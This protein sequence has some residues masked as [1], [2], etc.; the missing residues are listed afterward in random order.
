MF[1]RRPY[2]N[3]WSISLMVFAI[4]NALYV[5]VFDGVKDQSFLLGDDATVALVTGGFGL[6]GLWLGQ[7]QKFASGGP[8]QGRSLMPNLLFCMGIA[9]VVT[10][11]IVGMAAYA[12]SHG[13]IDLKGVIIGTI[14]ASV[15][16]VCNMMLGL[17][18]GL[19]E[20]DEDT[21]KK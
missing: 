15:F 11:E 10:L 17:G 19:V 8:V 2:W 7:A 21:G 6:I 18:T 3:V 20:E 14:L 5:W 16:G 1:Y 13:M 4:W 9:T 12:V